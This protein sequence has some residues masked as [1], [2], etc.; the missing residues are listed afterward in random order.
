[1]KIN[2]NLQNLFRLFSDLKIGRHLSLLKTK[3]LLCT[4]TMGKVDCEARRKRWALL[5]KN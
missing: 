2:G 3:N 1:M 4:H 5:N